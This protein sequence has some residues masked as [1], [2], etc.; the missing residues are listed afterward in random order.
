VALPSLRGICALGLALALALNTTACDKLLS[1]DN[2]GR[3]PAESLDDPGL[4]SA[5]EAGALQQFQCAWEQ[6]V[7]TGGV[8]SGEYWSAANFVDNH[9]W[10]WRSVPDVKANAGG[11]ATS[12]TQTFLGFYTPLQQARFQLDDFGKRLEKFTDAQVANRARMQA[13]AAAYGGYTYL[14]LAEGLC[15][16]V[17]DNG[18]K[19]SKAEVLKMAEDR[20]TAAIG[21]A[22]SSTD[23]QLVSLKNMAYVGRARERLLAGNLPGAAADAALVPPG[24]V[25]VAEYSETTPSRENRI[26]NLTVRNDFLS[27]APTYRGLTLENGQPDP[28]VRVAQPTPPR[29]GGDNVTAIWQP[30]KFITSANGA[31]PLTIASYAEAQL[32]LAEAT[33]GQAGLDAINRV[34]A[35]S[36]I[37][38]ITTVPSDFKALVIE[39]RRRQLFS[40]GQRYGDMLRF[41][42]PFQSGV[43][44]KGQTYSSLTCVPLPDVETRNN[45]NLNNG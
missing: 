15:D 33:G 4:M 31:V 9:T 6:Y 7:A 40:E 27:V 19:I 5:L 29:T 2:P 35:L 28:R 14:L 34:R 26:Y 38:A 39:E 22:G 36:S 32:I 17:I 45:P 37:P 13:E 1:V 20:F 10:E 23:A 43:N 11:C 25:R 24:F 16:V 3:V 44:R 30:Q 42:I 41:N 18:P 12:R 8:L 21:F